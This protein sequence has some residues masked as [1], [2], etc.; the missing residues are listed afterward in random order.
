V[1]DGKAVVTPVTVGP[2]DVTH[3]VVK[4]GLSEGDAVI[5]G[6]FKVLESIQ[7]DQRVTDEAT[8]QKDK[9]GAATQP[10]KK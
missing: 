3:T 9:G 8:V 6:P 10:A 1:V 2:S 5:S 7:H 4:S